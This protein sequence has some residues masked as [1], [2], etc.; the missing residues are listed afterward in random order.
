MGEAGPEAVMPLA[1]DSSG[2]LGVATSG[3]S[4]Q[5]I[6][7]Q[8]INQ[9]GSSVKATQSKATFD[10]QKTVVSVVIDALGRNA[11]GLRDAIVGVK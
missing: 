5:N 4:P 10:G 9:S 1:R 2:R 7:V 8:I 3:G 11:Y 6:Q